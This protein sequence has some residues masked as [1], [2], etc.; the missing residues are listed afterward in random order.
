MSGGTGKDALFG[1]PVTAA[2]GAAE[3]RRAFFSAAPGAA[4]DTSQ[5]PQHLQ[6]GR[7]GWGRA[8]VSCR[9]C[10]Q[11]AEVG[12]LALAKL[13]IPS[14]WLPAG[15]YNRLM[16]CPSCRRM[17]WCSVDWSGFIRLP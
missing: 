5:G 17:S 8:V 12:P 9:S 6:G 11:R 14:F 3:G 4:R 7:P 16:R 13:L 10:K 15:G 2:G 1:A